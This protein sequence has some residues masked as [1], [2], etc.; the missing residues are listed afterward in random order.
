MKH[1]TRHQ[2]QYQYQRWI[3]EMR[4]Q[5][6]GAALALAILLVLAVVAA[7]SAQAQIYT[8]NVLHAFTGLSDGANP[9]GGL[10]LDAQGNL[11]GTAYFGGDPA[12]ECGVVFKVDTSGNQTILYSFTAGDGHPRGNLVMDALGNLYGATY[13]NGA[14]YEVDTNGNHTVLY[15]FT[16]GADGGE[17][18]GSLVRDDQGNLYGTADMGGNLDCPYS[19]YHDTGCGTVFKLDP[20]GN[21]TVLYAFCTQANCADGAFPNGGL[22]RDTQGNLYGTTVLGG[23]YRNARDMPCGLGCGTVFKVDASGN[24]TVLHSFDFNPREGRLD[25]F[26][27]NGGL[28]MDGQGNLYGVTG[29]GGAGRENRGTVFKVDASGNESVLYSFGGRW[30]PP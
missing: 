11:Y 26:V 13:S 27:P 29:F 28:V 7:G 3:P 6:A 22:V 20:A 18:L 25:G 4:R 12:C 2:Y 19:I 14:I 21:L 16:G 24:Y 30:H 5:G 23:A 10:V 15:S 17:P 9:M 8:Y 1:S